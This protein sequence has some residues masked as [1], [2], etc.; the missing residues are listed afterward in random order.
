MPQSDS[1]FTGD[2]SD[3]SD[4]SSE[5]AK[6]D[7]PHSDSLLHGLTCQPQPVRPISAHPLAAAHADSSSSYG[8]IMAPPPP[9]VV[10]DEDDL[11]PD[12]DKV[13]VVSGDG[14]C[15]S[16]RWSQWRLLSTPSACG[17]IYMY[18]YTL[19]TSFLPSFLLIKV[20]MTQASK[21][22]RS[23]AVEIDLKFLCPRDGCG[24]RY[25]SNKSLKLHIRLKHAR[26]NQEPPASKVV[27]VPDLEAQ[28]SSVVQTFNPFV[29]YQHRRS[30]SAHALSLCGVEE[31]KSLLWCPCVLHTTRYKYA[32]GV[33]PASPQTEPLVNQ[34]AIDLTAEMEGVRKAHHP[35]LALVQWVQTRVL[36]GVKGKKERYVHWTFESDARKIISDGHVL[37]QSS[38][39]TQ[40]GSDQSLRDSEMAFM[41]GARSLVSLTT[42]FVTTTKHWLKRAASVGAPG[43]VWDHGRICAFVQVGDTFPPRKSLRHGT[44]YSKQ[45]V[46]IETMQCWVLGD[47]SYSEDF[48]DARDDAGYF[49]FRG[50][51]LT[52]WAQVIEHQEVKRHK[53]SLFK[54]YNSMKFAEDACNSLMLARTSSDMS[55][56]AIVAPH[57][58][59]FTMP[60]SLWKKDEPLT[61][62]AARLLLKAMSLFKQIEQDIRD[63]VVVRDGS[64]VLDALY[65]LCAH[66][67]TWN[68]LP[69]DKEDD[70][71]HAE[72]D[73]L[74]A[75]SDCM[76]G[77]D[78]GNVNT[79][80][81]IV[82]VTNPVVVFSPSSRSS[83]L[84]ACLSLLNSVS[85]LVM[86]YIRRARQRRTSYKLPR[87]TGT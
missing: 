50:S 73:G 36:A 85:S 57:P 24:N 80:Q 54:A 51:R 12:D 40:V 70:G 29:N 44:H 74:H 37:A 10:V 33:L 32:R 8:G 69:A 82:I 14:V 83:L 21:R 41:C 48:M 5:S 75:D 22:V 47:F 68:L 34:G 84:H 28:T 76:Q 2:V 52:T 66:T 18:I 39:L 4:S 31:H 9:S 87:Q 26:E 16:L 46:G 79:P 56:H 3:A 63:E 78:N 62:T 60:R 72:D 71:M 81:G 58:A 15:A 49:L 86:F 61:F 38:P 19:L 20:S 13:Y 7:V 77:D 27:V 23:K 42:G 45:N 53:E 43:D 64:C 35:V 1:L 67:K 25:G 11:L 55:A 59:C 30:A 17:Y 6:E 65:P